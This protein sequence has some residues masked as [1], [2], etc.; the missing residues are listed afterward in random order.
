MITRAFNDDI[1]GGDV[2]KPFRSVKKRLKKG[3]NARHRTISIEEY[4]ELLKAS[5]L[6]LKAALVIAYN[7]GMRLGEIRGFKW[8]QI[9]RKS[10]LIRLTDCD[11]KE[12][13]VLLFSFLFSFQKRKVSKK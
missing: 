10:G 8:S 13:T 1:I 11:T 6:H 7:T 3:Q 5:P 12:G 2:L 4:Q 9:N